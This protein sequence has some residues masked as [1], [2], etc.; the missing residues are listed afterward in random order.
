VLTA[1]LERLDGDDSWVACLARGRDGASAH[2]RVARKMASVA[3]WARLFDECAA[4]SR[5]RVYAGDITKPGFGL[6]ESD[7]VRLSE[8]VDVVVHCGALVNHL[9]SYS[10]LFRSNVVGTAEVMRF[11]VS[12]RRKRIHFVSTAGIGVGLR[13]REPVMETEL[14]GELWPRRPVRGDAEHGYA[15]G[16]TTTKWASEIM[17]WNLHRAC[18]VAV[19]VSRC[20][21]ILPHSEHAGV[22]NPT[23]AFT[24]LLYG[25]V[26]TQV[27]PRSFYADDYRGDRHY[28]G[29]AVDVVA[30]VIAEICRN[31]GVGFRTF[32]VSNSN[33][34]DGVSLDTMVDWI[35]SAGYRVERLQH[36]AWHAEFVRRLA[37]LP[38][39]ERARSPELIAQ[40]W[41]Q[42]IR[43]GKAAI[44]LDTANFREVLS[45]IGIARIPS[46]DE[47]YVRRCLAAICGTAT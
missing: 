44:K 45:R 6:A 41:Q 32:H 33:W 46:V 11:A 20:S 30:R 37:G 24:R 34:T 21:M 22:F 3:P 12:N 13:R 2:S 40:R 10:D 39:G 18:G 5:V 1:L 7:Y 31:T 43:E 4:D 25:I 14:A 29:V 28:D 35:A 19:D 8:T 38:N 23:D 42:P 36:T 47:S 27:A 16:Y 17:L 9:L 26:Q 15:L